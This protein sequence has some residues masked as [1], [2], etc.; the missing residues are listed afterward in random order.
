MVPI[1]QPQGTEIDIPIGA[2]GTVNDNWTNETIGILKGEVAVVP[3][4]PVRCGSEG[5]GEITAGG[6]GTLSY[7]GDAIVRDV[8]VHQEPVPVN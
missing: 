7:S 8:L 6:N 5:V 4:C 3:C 2:R 1:R